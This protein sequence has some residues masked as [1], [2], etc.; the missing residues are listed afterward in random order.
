MI[1]DEFDATNILGPLAKEGL[2][3]DAFGTIT[4]FGLAA[5]SGL[6]SDVLVAVLDAGLGSKVLGPSAA[7]DYRQ[8]SF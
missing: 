2:F 5:N 8:S 7:A 3:V 4:S 6:V 1:P